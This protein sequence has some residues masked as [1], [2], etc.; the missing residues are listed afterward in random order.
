MNL[1]ARM[2]HALTV[3]EIEKVDREDRFR[4]LPAGHQCTPA[5]T[6]SPGPI[7]LGRAG[8]PWTEGRRG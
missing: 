4:H 1:V 3:S 7:R 8:E 5:C 6:D 2:L